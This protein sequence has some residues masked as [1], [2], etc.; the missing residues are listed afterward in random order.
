ML[1][2][3]RQ[4]IEATRICLEQSIRIA[5]L[6]GLSRTILRIARLLG[7]SRTILRSLILLRVNN[8]MT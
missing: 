5:R 8:S 2:D 1:R 6:L 4:K 7:L 3:T